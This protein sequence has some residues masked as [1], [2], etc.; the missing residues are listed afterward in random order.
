MVNSGCQI[1][2]ILESNS[3]P[4][5]IYGVCVSSGGISVSLSNALTMIEGG[6]PDFH[7][8]LTTPSA[9]GYHGSA[10]IYVDYAN[11]GTAA[12]P[13]PLLTV[14]AAQNGN[15]RAFL[16]LD[17]NLFSSGFW[18]SSEQIGFSHSVQILASGTAPGWLQPGESCRIPIYYAGWQQPWDFSYPKIVFS[19]NTQTADS[20]ELVDWASYAANSRPSG[21]TDGQWT[22]LLQQI[23]NSLACFSSFL[24][25]FLT[26]V[27]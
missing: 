18:T 27:G 10:T 4:A 5:G 24:T 8:Y 17:Q 23:R 13:A 6:L 25:R 14:T 2:A 7:V 11:T 16:S 3:I 20:M 22:N 21:V 12:M 1:T 26:L 9:V 15:R 19:V